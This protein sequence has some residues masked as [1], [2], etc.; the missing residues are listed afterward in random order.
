MP[1]KE[2]PNQFVGAPLAKLV[3]EV[4]RR[5]VVDIEEQF[6][7]ETKQAIY[8]DMGKP[9]WLTYATGMRQKTAWGGEAE[10]QAISKLLQVNI[11]V[12]SAGHTQKYPSPGNTTTIYLVHAN[13][14]N[15]EEDAKNHYHYE[16]PHSIY[17]R[18]ASRLLGPPSFSSLI[19]QRFASGA[20]AVSYLSGSSQG[21]FSPD[22][23]SSSAISTHQTNVT[24]G[25]AP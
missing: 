8:R 10:I 17:Q 6:S 9:D 14:S 5:R 21:I 20:S 15:K 19:S 24:P 4:F 16:L 18:H 25:T 7:E 13:A 3:C 1:K 22:D 23:L 11:H 12:K 2:T